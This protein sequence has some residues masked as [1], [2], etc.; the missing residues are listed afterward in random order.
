MRSAD[1]LREPLRAEL[2]PRFA[3]EGLRAAE[4]LPR[5]AV[6]ALVLGFAAERLPPCAPVPARFEAVAFECPR[7]WLLVTRFEPELAPFLRATSG[8][9]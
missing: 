2:L 9:L 8:L 6:D 3:V 7:A 5:F 4:L 1:G